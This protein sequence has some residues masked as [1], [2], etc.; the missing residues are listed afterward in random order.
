MEKPY[1]SNPEMYSCCILDHGFNTPIHVSRKAY[2]KLQKFMTYS[3]NIIQILHILLR[4]NQSCHEPRLGRLDMNAD[5]SVDLGLI[6]ICD[7]S[8]CTVHVKNQ[9]K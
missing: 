4:W 2:L 7:T 6:N 8:H 9:Q 3:Y 5:P 1:Y